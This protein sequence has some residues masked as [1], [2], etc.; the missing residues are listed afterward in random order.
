[1]D[2]ASLL[3]MV[4]ER[5]RHAILAQLRERERSVSELVKL[6]GDEQTNV[7]HHLAVLRQAGLVAA[8]REGR[9]QVYRLSDP[10]VRALLD[11]VRELANHL[12]RVAYTT[13]LGLPTD[14]AFHGYG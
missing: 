4:S 7:S 8:R 12:E 2:E 9:A 11:Q 1:M 6:L 5:T 3:R 13:R 14:P 10:Q